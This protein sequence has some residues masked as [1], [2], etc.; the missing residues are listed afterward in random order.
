MSPQ[1]FAIITVNYNGL[2]DTLDLLDSLKKAKIPKNISIQTI[3]VDNASQDDSINILTEKF[4]EIILI[5]NHKNLGFAGGNNVGIKK[6]NDQKADWIVLIN[7]DCFVDDNFF[8]NLE[9]SAINDPKTGAL[10]GL[11]YFAPGFEYQKHYSKRDSGKVIWYGGGQFD[12]LNILG[13]HRHV[14]EVDNGNLVT[15]TTDFI[16]GALMIIRADIL[17]KTGGFDEKYF[18]YLED[19]D[20]CQQ[21]RMAGFNLIFDPSIKIWHKVAQSSGI[22][23]P[24]NDY[25][26]TRNRL[27]FGFKY[28]KT[29]TKLAL[30]REAAKKLFTGRQAEKTAIKDYFTGKLY[31]GSWLK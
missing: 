22:G 26:I 16:S 28:A 11:I 24:L 6:A 17:Q 3:V 15:E 4:P 2:A 21:I 12:W 10:G 5:A 18:M 9:N 25:F 8:V 14:D 27:L 31:Q 29:R 19:V 30:V 20:L 13:S 23:S 7:N 1:K